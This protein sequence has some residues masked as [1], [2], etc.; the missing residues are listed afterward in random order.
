MQKLTAWLLS[1]SLIAWSLVSVSR[2]A[3]LGFHALGTGTCPYEVSGDGST[4][5][6][7]AANGHAA[8]WRASSGWTDLGFTGF[9]YDTSFDGAVVIGWT[10][11]STSNLSGNRAFR[12]TVNTGTELLPLAN[13]T[14]Y[15]SQSLSIS[16]DGSTVVG[17]EQ[18]SG[19]ARFATRWSAATGTVD[20]R[21]VP[22]M[23]SEGSGST[24]GVVARGVS[25]DGST[26]VGCTINTTSCSWIWTAGS[27]TAT[28]LP[29]AL[30]SM[31]ALSADGGT[32][33]GSGGST[34]FGAALWTAADGVTMLH[35]GD[36]AEAR[37]VSGDG[38][39]VTGYYYRNG[40]QTAFAWDREHGFC[41]LQDTLVN[42]YHLDLAGWRLL[43]WAYVSD[44]GHTFTG[45][46]LDATG[47]FGGWV[48]TIP[49][50]STLALLGVGALGLLGYAWR[51]R[52]LRKGILL[53][54]VA[55]TLSSLSY[56]VARADVLNMPA[57]QTSL[58]V[59]PVGDPGNANDTTGYGS[60]GY[61]Y[62]MG[63]YEVTNAQYCEF[64]NATLPAINCAGTGTVL[65]NDTYGLYNRWMETGVCGGINYNSGAATNSHF[66]VKSGYENKPVVYVSWFDSVRFANWLQNGQGTGSTET[67]TYTITGGGKNSGTVA[68]R[69][70]WDNAHKHWV[71][72]SENEWYKAAYYDPNKAG[73]AGYWDYPTGSDSIPSND[74]LGSDPGNNAN[75]YQGDYTNTSPYLTVAGEFE[76]S[77][78]PY[79][80]FDQAG[81]VWE[82]NEA[83]TGSSRGLRGGSW[84]SGSSLLTAFYRLSYDPTYE[85]G[86]IGFRVA[87]VPEPGSIALLLAGA[88]A[89]LIW[90]RRRALRG[91]ILVCCVAITLSSLFSGVARADVLNMP[92][93]QTSIEMVSVGDANNPNDN[94]GYGSV[95]YAYQ[96]DKYEVTNAQYCE[97]LNAKAVTDTYGLYSTY[98]GSQVYGGINRTG[99][100]GSFTYSLKSGYENK[101]VV[102]VCWYDSLRFVNWLQNGQGTGSTE[103]GTY[104]ITGG[105]FNSGTVTIPDAA[106]RA[107]WDNAYKHWVL[108]SENEWYKAAY[109]DPDKPGG[110]GY[111]DCPTGSDTAPVNTILG[112]DG[113]N[114]AN[115]FDGY[116]TGTGGYSTTSPYLT[117]VGEFENSDSPYGTFDQGGNVFEW[118]E[119]I[120]GSSRGLRGGG[121]SGGSRSLAASSRDSYYYPTYES[122]YIGFRV[123]SVPEPGSIALLLAGAVSG[124][125]WR[126]RRTA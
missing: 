106:T 117:V 87:S 12:W 61:A 49:E 46:G 96:I 88:V 109:Y 123:T 54:C 64:L 66:S 9:A 79:G 17:T 77:D 59:V 92:V 1:L 26:I 57:G 112:I 18:L 107:S 102:Y 37:D 7:R 24:S 121:W 122:Y 97:F 3:S 111:W 62:Q 15:G 85:Y 45:L 75:F 38:S 115:F 98:M 124:L 2:A 47:H 72:P 100:S 71:L 118:N 28:P 44:D 125:I 82:W 86:D 101:P 63:K 51:R 99:S 89:G 4:I 74:L 33:V 11:E 41:S 19:G 67:G 31:W 10:G 14:D 52:A 39:M 70:T 105:G 84:L 116:G 16:A 30:S 32:V 126:R 55:I 50:P 104:T 56:R 94:T 23:P 22:G 60:V 119:A 6:G 120:I 42:D 48:A 110:A 113:G 80:T 58:E 76:N 69:A 34:A 8:I 27:N 29:S 25:G 43:S 95:G 83:L 68:T 73:G 40:S 65:A 81:N 91:G 13:S 5:V 36:N 78:S 21:T 90:W 103:S 35:L 53:C 114:N 93:G 20:M 108:P